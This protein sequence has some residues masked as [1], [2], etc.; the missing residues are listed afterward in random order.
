MRI[1]VCIKQ[2]PDTT[3]VDLTGDLTLE[4]SFVAQIMNPADESAVEL[5]LRIRDEHGGTVTAITMG[6]ERAET[7]L[8]EVLSRGV[9]EAVH[10]T[11]RLFAGSDT[12]VT[13]RFLAKA[14]A[15]L[16]GF[17]LILCGR[18]AADG[19][20]GQVGPMLAA[21]LDMPCVANITQAAVAGRSL[22]ACQL[23][24]DGLITWQTEL[25]TVLTLCE[26][27]YRL[28]LPTIMG[29][30][31]ARTAATRQLNAADLDV[32]VSGLKQSPTRV[33]KVHAKPTGIRPCKKLPLGETLAELHEKG[34]L[35]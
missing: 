9:D 27:R 34:V 24:E 2:V 16:G 13:A 11:D 30:R 15:H 26:W 19:E 20:T 25:P 28:R 1:L 7:M 17:D 14:A 12:L 10:L 18:R 3:E 32:T 29:L 23:T 31:K 33:V 22:T 5:A 4:R 21:M 8:R 35:P 6:P